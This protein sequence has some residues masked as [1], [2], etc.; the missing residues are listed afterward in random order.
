M[1][2]TIH[3]DIV[4]AE[5]S[6]YSGIAEVV[7]A[8][9]QR[10]ELGIYPRHTPLLT[11]LKPGSVRIKVPN[12]TEEELVYV[13]GGILEVQ[14]HVVTILSDSAIRG[15]DLDEAKALE[16]MRA[17]EEAMKDKTASID[18]AQAQAELAQAVAQL[19]AIKKL[20]KHN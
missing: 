11:T 18:Y 20:R 12:Q 14:P 8:P 6:L 19:A 7:I 17:A 2:M 15:T 10:G 13:S 3:V 1:A 9:G 4:S 16:A 5:K